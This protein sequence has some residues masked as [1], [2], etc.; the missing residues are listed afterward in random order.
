MQTVSLSDDLSFRLR[1]DDALNLSCELSSDGGQPSAL[2]EH[3]SKLGSPGKSGRGLDIHLIKRIPSAAGLGGASSNAAA[4]LIA[5]NAIWQLKFSKEQLHAIAAELGSDVPFFLYG[6]AAICQGRGEKITPFETPASLDIVIA[7]PNVALSTKDVFSKVQHQP[8][9]EHRRS[10]AMVSC[11]SNG[12]PAGIP[13]AMFNRLAAPAAA[14]TNQVD[15]T[16]RH[17]DRVGCEGHQM[18]GSGSSHFGVFRNRK[19]ALAAANKL[20]AQDRNLRVFVTRTT[21]TPKTGNAMECS[22]TTGESQWK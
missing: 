17:F 12:Q 15:E 21:S 18:S 4:A 13:K 16:K 7:K 11:L 3:A 2:R 6:G 5:A 14:L 20:I 19:A 22:F 1:D 10:S 8:A 9:T